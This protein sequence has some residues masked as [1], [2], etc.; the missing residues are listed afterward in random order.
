MNYGEEFGWQRAFDPDMEHK[1]IAVLVDKVMDQRHS[2]KSIKKFGMILK[3]S[4][5]ET[6]VLCHISSIVILNEGV[7][8]YKVKDS[9]LDFGY[10]LHPYIEKNNSYIIRLYTN[11]H[12][13]QVINCTWDQFTVIKVEEVKKVVY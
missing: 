12:N 2:V 6:E 10:V 7:S 4:K 9:P 13:K 11:D 5:C 3:M 1:K 8:T